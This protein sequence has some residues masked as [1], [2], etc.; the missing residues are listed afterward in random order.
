MTETGKLTGVLESTL[1]KPDAQEIDIVQLCHEAVQLGVA[2]VCVNPCWV[3]TASRLLH[4]TKVAIVTVVGFPLGAT[5][6]QVKVQEILAAKALGAQEV[7]AVI[8]IGQVKSAMWAQVETELKQMVETAHQCG[9]IIKIIIECALLTESEKRQAAQLV[10]KAGADY[11]KTST[12]FHGG[13][14]MEDVMHLQAWSGPSMKIKAS[15]GIR[16]VEQAEALLAAGA[17]RLGTSHA[18]ELSLSG[19]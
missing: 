11:I 7:D 6:T 17:H 14:T 18:R 15:G 1:L 2:A 3:R 13:A 16:S 12:G 19:N 9:L 10:H 8:N 5:L 4:A